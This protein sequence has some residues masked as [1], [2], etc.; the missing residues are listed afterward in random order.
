M[1]RR[2]PLV[3]GIL[4]ATPDSFYDG[5]QHEDL[6]AH[7]HRLIE[8]G[9]DWLDIGGESTRPGAAAVCVEEECSR[10]LPL[11]AALAGEVPISVDTS[12]PAVAARALAAGACI[13]NDVTGLSDPDMAAVT[14]DAWATVVMHMRGT[15]ATMNQCTDYTDVTAEVADWLAERAARARSEVV[16]ID[17][18]V[19]FAKTTEQSL[20]LLANTHVLTRL[21]LPVLV[22]ASRKSFIGHTLLLPRAEDRLPGSLAAAA[23]AWHGGA[24][25]FRV[26]DVAATRQALDLIHAVDSQRS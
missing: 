17:P 3:V 19:G 9:A 10:V 13:I 2:R 7:G 14:A 24:D 20:T 15:P 1:S 12:K 25:A 23:M 6:V 21:G 11:I 16:W 26:H 18:G 4:N 22:G 8:E 5:G